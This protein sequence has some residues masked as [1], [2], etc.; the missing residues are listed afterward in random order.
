VEARRTEVRD[1]A[2]ITFHGC[3]YRELLAAW[4]GDSSDAIRAHAAAIATRFDL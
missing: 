3:S 1:F 2:E 4:S